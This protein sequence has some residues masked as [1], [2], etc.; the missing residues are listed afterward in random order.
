L[1]GRFGRQAIAADPLDCRIGLEVRTAFAITMGD[2]VT[3][4]APIIF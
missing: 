3:R 2:F 1:S 4:S